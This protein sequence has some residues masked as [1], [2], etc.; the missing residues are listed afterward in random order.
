MAEGTPSMYSNTLSLSND[1]ITSHV[2]EILPSS[3]A[4]LLAIVVA[5]TALSS[6]DQL[7]NSE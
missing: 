7:L 3:S 5:L 6:T 2:A 1:L 4:Q